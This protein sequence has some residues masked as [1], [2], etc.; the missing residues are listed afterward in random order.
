VIVFPRALARQFRAVLRRLVSP[1]GS[2]SRSPTILVR[3]SP[4]GLTLQAALEEAAVRYHQPDSLA[5]A[6]IA[7]SAEVLVT[8]E[9]AGADNITLEE[10]A[11]GKGRAHWSE[12]GVARSFS[13]TTVAAEGVVFPDVPRKLLPPGEGFL[14]ALSEAVQ[15]A[16][17]DCARPA[18]SR[19][20]LRGSSGEIVATDGRQLLIQSGFNFPWKEDVLVP[21]LPAFTGRGLPLDLPVTIGRTGTHIAVEIGPWLFLLAIDTTG[22]FPDCQQVVPRRS[23]LRTELSLS[24]EDAEVLLRALPHLPGKEGKDGPITLEVGETVSVRAQEESGEEITELVLPRSQASGPSLRLATN[25][26]YLHRA[27]SLGFQHFLIACPEQPIVCRDTSRLN[28]WMVLDAKSA[29]PAARKTAGPD[30]GTLSTP[31]ESDPVPPKRERHQP[32]PVRNHEET[33]PR[34]GSVPPQ[35]PNALPCG[36]DELIR[37]AEDLRAVLTEASA[38]AA[39]LAAGLKR[40]RRQGRSLEAAIAALRQFH[41]TTR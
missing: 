21:A 11:R 1:T 14:A 34:N 18:L 36:I 16:A 38:R 15:T 26:R 41:P 9:G 4:D 10:V 35:E 12:A 17:R 30:L 37:E 5:P 19:L 7:F 27:L 13:F 23:A 2:R 40:Q 20:L 39:R 22:R 3:A 24:A 31:T 32:M 29:L 6:S 25:R 33:E 28:W 8:I